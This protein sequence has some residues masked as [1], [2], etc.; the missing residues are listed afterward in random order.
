MCNIS[1]YASFSM[2][3]GS[4]PS[5]QPP[6]WTATYCRLSRTAYSTYLLLSS[7]FGGRCLHPELKDSQEEMQLK[8]YKT[9]TTPT[10]RMWN[11]E[12]SAKS[13]VIRKFQDWNFYEQWRGAQYET[14][15]ILKHDS[16]RSRYGVRPGKRWIDAGTEHKH[17]CEVK[18]VCQ[19]VSEQIYLFP[20]WQWM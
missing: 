16:N 18:W 15:Q 13:W 17:I 14:K 4:Q 6:R 9:M 5:V 8:C 10:L 7:T 20:K 11:L 19:C 12:F 1:Y 2:V 3:A